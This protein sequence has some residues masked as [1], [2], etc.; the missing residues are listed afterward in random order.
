MSGCGC[1][2]GCGGCGTGA[3]GAAVRAGRPLWIPA[4]EAE[5]P[6]GVLGRPYVAP[7]IPS[8]LLRSIPR[9]RSVPKGGK[10]HPVAV[11]PQ[12]EE[13]IE[14]AGIECKQGSM[15]DEEDDTTW[16]VANVIIAAVAGAG[17]LV[18]WGGAF[19]AY[20]TIAALAG[21]SAIVT[22][23]VTDSLGT[24][25]DATLH[26]GIDQPLVMGGHLKVCVVTGRSP[27]CA[28]DPSTECWQSNP[29]EGVLPCLNQPGGVF[30]PGTEGGMRVV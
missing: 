6:P 4:S 15:V 12:E 20:A 16:E 22:E 8:P 30:D 1:G 13:R 26:V 28:D 23:A 9:P 14:Y 21:V 27:D 10:R 19:V 11:V 25:S 3:A 17:A 29:P 24:E 18:T 7:L 2:G 5:D